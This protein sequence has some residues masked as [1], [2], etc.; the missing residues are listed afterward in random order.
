MSF[1]GFAGLMNTLRRRGETWAPIELYQLRIIV[2]YAIATLVGSLSTIPL[3]ELFGQ[4]EGLQWLG[5]VM[6]AVSSALGFGSMVSDTRLGLGTP[7]RTRVRAT[8]ATI[9]ILGLLAFLG[10]AIRG[11]LPRYRVALILML[12]MPAGTFVYRGGPSPAIAFTS[13]PTATGDWVAVP[14]PKGRLHRGLSN[15]DDSIGPGV[16]NSGPCRRPDPEL[17]E[18]TPLLRDGGL[19]WGRDRSDLPYGGSQ[20]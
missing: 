4:R 10:T 6:V 12:A 15:Q 9:T 13:S 17:G 14:G 18:P 2:A 11:A 8:F 16:M 20:C 19:T 1:A 3:V 7:V 5:L